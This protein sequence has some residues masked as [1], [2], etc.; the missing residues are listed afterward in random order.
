MQERDVAGVA[1]FAEI[2]QHTRIGIVKVVAH[3]IGIGIGGQTDEGETESAGAMQN[4]EEADKSTIRHP[5]W[6][7]GR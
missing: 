3:F 4:V 1:A 7:S 5:I 2:K 6:T